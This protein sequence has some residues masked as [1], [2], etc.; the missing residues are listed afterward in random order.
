MNDRKALLPLRSL[1]TS[2]GLRNERMWM[3][4][5]DGRSQRVAFAW[6]REVTAFWWAFF[7]WRE[8]RFERRGS[9]AVRSMR[10]SSECWT[11]FEW[12]LVSLGIVKVDG[13]GGVKGCR[14]KFEVSF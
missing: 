8:V 5:S 10:C 1:N 14:Q 13:V 6:S 12:V 11:S 7:C 2:L 9:G 4:S 3:R